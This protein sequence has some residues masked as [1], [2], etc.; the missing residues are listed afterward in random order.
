MWIKYPIN[1]SFLVPCNTAIDQYR[2]A[3]LEGA[4]ITV[5]L[6][7]QGY[8]RR[9]RVSVIPDS[10]QFFWADPESARPRFTRPDRFGARL[11]AAALALFRQGYF[12]TYEIA[13]ETGTLTIRHLSPIC[14]RPDALLPEEPTQE[15]NTPL[16]HKRCQGLFT[17]FTF[18]DLRAAEPPQR[19]G[20]YVIQVKQDGE[21]VADIVQRVTRVVH[22]LNWSMVGDRML[23][24]IKR[25]DGIGLCPIIYIGSAGTRPSSNH[26]LAGRYQD[27]GR[28]HTAMYP[29]WAL[30]YYGWELRYGWKQE[31]RPA[32]LEKQLK[33]EYRKIHRD[34]LPALVRR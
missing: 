13:H 4:T 20:V 25:L 6:S 10:P 18:Q 34:T 30:L 28:R 31:D 19:K 32:D 29:L 1:S 22:T 33:E 24:R 5:Q 23:S 16:S 3:L 12:G 8:N 2:E 14:I 26:T 15:E 7:P 27:F 17:D 21:P 11:R 9:A